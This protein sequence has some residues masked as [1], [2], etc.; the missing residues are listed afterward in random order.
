MQ[1]SSVSSARFTAILTVTAVSFFLLLLPFE[2]ISEIPVD[3]DAKPFFAPLAICALLPNGR[4]GL[5]VALGVALGEGL[6]DLKEGYELDDPIGFFGYIAGFW[7]ASEIFNAAPFK[8]WALIVGSIA[9]AAVQAGLEASSFLLFGQEG[10]T[11]ALYSAIGNTISHGIIFG[12]IPL[13]FLVPALHALSRRGAARRAGAGAPQGWSAPAW[14]AARS[15]GSDR[16]R[17]V[18]RGGRG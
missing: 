5:A 3:I 4:V 9:C 6:R 7:V 17:R 1:D 13:L 12:A 15:A 16:R 2:L 10:L 11:V 14:G 18:S 8:R